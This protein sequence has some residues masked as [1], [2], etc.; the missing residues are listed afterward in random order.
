MNDVPTLDEATY[1]FLEATLTNVQ[2]IERMLPLVRKSI[3]LAFSRIDVDKGTRVITAGD[4]GDKFFIVGSGCFNLTSPEINDGNVSLGQ[5]C[6]GGI[7]AERSLYIARDFLMPF[8]LTCEASGHLFVL[9]RETYWELVDAGVDGKE[10]ESVDFLATL[11][12]FQ[13]ASREQLSR[14]AKAGTLRTLEPGELIFSPGYHGTDDLIILK[15]GAIE[16]Q[17]PKP[18]QDPTAGGWR[19]GDRATRRR[20]NSRSSESS[21]ASSQSSDG[22][23]TET[24][25]FTLVAGDAVAEETLVPLCRGRLAASNK[26]SIIR[27]SEQH[28]DLLPEELL[29]DAQRLVRFHRTSNRGGRA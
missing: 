29:A 18:P 9:P 26:C 28:F 1:K 27:L 13:D 14:I 24:A 15:S 4:P 20:V 2:P 12:A 3:L 10:A 11:P 16:V 17:R 8:D 5:Y 22:A 7:I 6:K 23:S 19:P 25:L 21:R